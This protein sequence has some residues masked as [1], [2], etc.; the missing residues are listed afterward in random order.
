[1]LKEIK[2]RYNR[3]EQVMEFVK[4]ADRMIEKYGWQDK[5]VYPYSYPEKVVKIVDDLKEYSSYT[6][7]SQSLLIDMA[8]GLAKIM[9]AWEE[10]ENEPKV[11]IKMVRGGKVIILPKSFAEIIIADGDAVLA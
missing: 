4:E 2:G 6:Y 3:M 5:V 11:S 1:M 9:N 10:Q 7:S 8:N